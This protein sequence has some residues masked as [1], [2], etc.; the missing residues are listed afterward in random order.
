MPIRFQTF[1]SIKERCSII[2]P[3]VERGLWKGPEWEESGVDTS[4]PLVDSNVASVFVVPRSGSGAGPFT[5]EGS[6][7][8][9]GIS[10]PPKS[11]AITIFDQKRKRMDV[12]NLKREITAANSSPK[13][14]N[15]LF[16]SSA[17]CRF[18][19]ESA[20]DAA[21]RRRPQTVD[22]DLSQRRR[23]PTAL[24]TG[25]MVFAMSGLQGKIPGFGTNDFVITS[26]VI[27]GALFNIQPF[28]SSKVGF[29]FAPTLAIWFFSLGS[30][31]NNVC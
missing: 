20:I 1:T 5:N 30:V 28:G 4:K 9:E 21:S 22:A 25:T 2:G 8:K 31:E 23:C 15:Q 17:V 26:I 10:V 29:T 16:A 13:S 7:V 11:D 19:P 14:L 18:S 3:T 12:L 6:N 24:A 27:L